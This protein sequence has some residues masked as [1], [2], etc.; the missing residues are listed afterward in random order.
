[1]DKSLLDQLNYYYSKNEDQKFLEFKTENKDSLFNSQYVL[2][3]NNCQDII[4]SL[5]SKNIESSINKLKALI[6]EMVNKLNETTH[7]MKDL[8]ISETNDNKQPNNEKNEEFENYYKKEAESIIN[9]I[10]QNLSKI[11]KST[12]SSEYEML[13]HVKKINNSKRNELKLQQLK[14]T[15]TEKLKTFNYSIKEKNAKI[16]LIENKKNSL[17]DYKLKIEKLKIE[18]NSNSERM[19]KEIAQNEQFQK[20]IDLL[21]HELNEL[22]NNNN[23]ELQREQAIK[24]EQN[25]YDKIV[26]DNALEINELVDKKNKADNDLQIKR[27]EIFKRFIFA[28]YLMYKINRINNLNNYNNCLKEKITKLKDLSTKLSI[29]SAKVQDETNNVDKRFLKYQL[30]LQGSANNII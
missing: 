1:M 9:D 29:K 28:Y 23:N 22:K 13:S 18:Y 5:E 6:M 8:Q 16:L 2:Y 24:D 27:N 25:K 12:Y 11:K 20:D 7:I 21:L 19:T 15:L 30:F 14:N 10:T 4:D 3:S 17:N 26:N